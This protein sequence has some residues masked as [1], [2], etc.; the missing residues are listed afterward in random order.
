M[1]RRNAGAE[2]EKQPAH[3][4]HHGDWITVCCWQLAHFR[5]RVSPGIPNLSPGHRDD[6]LR[7]K[8][9]G[10]WEENFGSIKDATPGGNDAEV[11]RKGGQRTRALER[12]LDLSADGRCPR[13]EKR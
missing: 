13:M 8:R 4:R 7:G 1:R 6:C 9:V 12:I 11:L 5:Q 2:V 10:G 3:S